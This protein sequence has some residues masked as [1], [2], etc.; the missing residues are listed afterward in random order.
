MKNVV[1]GAMVALVMLGLVGCGCAKKCQPKCH[2]E[3]V[4]EKMEKEYCGK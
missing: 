3:T 2:K 1:K 4:C